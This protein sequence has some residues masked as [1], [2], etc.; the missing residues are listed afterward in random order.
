MVG[1][2]QDNFECDASAK[3]WRDGLSRV[4][5]ERIEV[6]I[7]GGGPGGLAVSR[8]L[9]TRN[10]SNVVLEGG[11]RARW[12]WEQ[13]YDSL[14][15]HTGKHL[16]SLPVMVFAAR[17]SPFPNRSE[18]AADPEDYVDRFHLSVRA[19]VEATGLE[20]GNGGWPVETD[21][22]LFRAKAVVA[23]TG[24]VR[25]RTNNQR[26][27]GP[28]A[29][30]LETYH[31]HDR[32]ERQLGRQQVLV[33]HEP[34][35]PALVG[36]EPSRRAPCHQDLYKQTQGEHTGAY[37]RNQET[38]RH[39]FFPDNSTPARGRFRQG[40]F[41]PSYEVWGLRPQLG[42]KSEFKGSQGR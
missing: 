27:T 36:K 2:L 19:G 8:Q 30:Y 38:M 13:V 28:L 6:A 31:D 39:L 35:I 34:G 20:L 1:S 25:L 16:S 22:G 14:R 37:C 42:S 12:M 26:K 21:A 5:D 24:M 32:R 11:D 29:V 3:S 23:A 33:G 15:L 17:K 4:R 9:A 41:A 10:I 7:V 18:F 40:S